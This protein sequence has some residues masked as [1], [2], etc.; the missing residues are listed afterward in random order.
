MTDSD[1]ST[2][3]SRVA[4]EALAILSQLWKDWARGEL[5]VKGPKMLTYQPMADAAKLLNRIERKRVMEMLQ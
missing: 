4:D 5:P 2:D 3:D 1:T